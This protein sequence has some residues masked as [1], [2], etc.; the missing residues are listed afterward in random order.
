MNL[1]KLHQI[2]RFSTGLG[3]LVLALGFSSIGILSFLN[4]HPENKATGLF[5]ETTYSIIGSYISIL[6]GAMFLGA[7]IF[8]AGTLLR[9]KRSLRT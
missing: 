8:F 9:A 5:S 6:V 3:L 1:S 2:K 7:A 4:E